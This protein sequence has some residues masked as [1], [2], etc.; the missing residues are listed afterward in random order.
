M[1]LS[2]L[3][4]VLLFNGAVMAETLK[5]TKVYRL[6][7]SI[8]HVEA[9]DCIVEAAAGASTPVAGAPVAGTPV[10]GAPVAGTPVAGTPVAGTP[11]AGTPVAGTPVAGTPDTN[12]CKKIKVELA[13]KDSKFR[14]VDSSQETHYVVKFVSVQRA[15]EIAVAGTDEEAIEEVIEEA[16]EEAI[17]DKGKGKEVAAIAVA[18]AVKIAVAAAVAE[19]EREREILKEAR[20]YNAGLVN[21]EF[22]YILHK[23]Y[24]G[25]KLDKSTSV[26]WEGAVSGPL[27]VPFKYRGNDGSL[28]GESSIGMYAGYGLE[29][30]IWN[31]FRLPLTPFIAGGLTQIST[32]NDND[33]ATNNTGLTVAV[34]LLIQ[35]WGGLNIG[36]VYGQDRIGKKDWKHE[37]RGWTSF[38]VGWEL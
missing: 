14:V 36:L 26:S 8:S 31:S 15:D 37:G 9:T 20:T 4:M 22:E 7:K 21:T 6:H 30:E 12:K 17:E 27:V 34:G 16:I 29:P 38:M 3:F 33:E 11:V 35:N 23:T 18:E 2:V 32:T 28:S 24:G 13:P 1:K 5:E 19:D 10:A 25:V